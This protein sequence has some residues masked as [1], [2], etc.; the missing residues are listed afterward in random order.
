M[1]SSNH[2]FFSVLVLCTHYSGEY[3]E[4]VMLL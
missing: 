1:L 2:D 4:F 3:D